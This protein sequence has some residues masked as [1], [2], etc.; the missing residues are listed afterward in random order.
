MKAGE[1]S[2]VLATGGNGAVSRSCD[3]Q[4]RLLESMLIL[5]RPCAAPVVTLSDNSDS[6]MINR[7]AA[8]RIINSTSSGERNVLTG[9]AMAPRTA[10]AKKQAMNSG[11]SY[12]IM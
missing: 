2:S 9:T 1:L 12:R 10:Q 3:K 5:V 8:S 6:T 7:A 4:G 11:E